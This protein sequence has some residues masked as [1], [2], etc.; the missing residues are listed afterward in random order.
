MFSEERNMRKVTLLSAGT[1]L[2]VAAALAL[3]GSALAQGKH[4]KKLSYEDA[5][6][7]CK[8]FVDEGVA[9]WDQTQAR[10][11]RGAACMKR[12]GYRI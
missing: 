4:A 1:G 12:Y 2:S 9:S 8:K 5:W 11:S 10:Y 6:A 3:G 7:V